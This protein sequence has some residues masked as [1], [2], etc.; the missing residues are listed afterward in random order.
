VIGESAFKQLLGESKNR[1][2]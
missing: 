2:K 1:S